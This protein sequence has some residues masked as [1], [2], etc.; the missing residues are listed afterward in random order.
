VPWQA[1][2]LY[3]PAVQLAQAVHTSAFSPSL[4]SVSLNSVAQVAIW[5]SEAFVQLTCVPCLAFLTGVQSLQVASLAVSQLLL[6]NLPLWQLVHASHFFSDVIQNFSLQLAQTCAPCEEHFVPV[7][8]FPL[9]HVHL[10]SSHFLVAEFNV[11]PE[12]QDAHMCVPVTLQFEPVVPTPL[13]HVHFLTVHV[14]AVEL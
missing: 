4:L 9:E 10:F 5:L 6:S 13:V 3:L 11:Y 14:A 8:P 1:D 2:A 7:V 12:L